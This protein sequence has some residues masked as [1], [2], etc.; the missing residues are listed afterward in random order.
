MSTQRSRSKERG[1][2]GETELSVTAQ[3][4]QMQEAKK[5]QF[6]SI[7]ANITA[8]IA[9]VTTQT[10]NVNRRL[11]SLENVRTAP[12]AVFGLPA[13]NAL[14]DYQPQ[15]RLSMSLRPQRQH[16][17]PS[18]P[19]SCA[20]V[21]LQ[22][23]YHEPSHYCT[24]PKAL[25]TLAFISCGC[26]RWRFLVMRAFRKNCDVGYLQKARRSSIATRPPWQGR[27]EQR[28][29]MMLGMM[30]YHEPSKFTRRVQ[31]PPLF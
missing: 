16:V 18:G 25:I 3:L 4:G 12:A 8:L 15:P 9:L 29:T 20:S 26:A 14:R 21:W 7:A 24:L 30:L 5:A 17:V 31:A 27:S 13:A 6:T 19:S 1:D 11:D 2:R 28:L 23:L 22:E 10:T